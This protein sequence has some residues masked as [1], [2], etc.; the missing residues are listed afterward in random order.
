MDQIRHTLLEA[1]VTEEL[2]DEWVSDV[3]SPS[4]FTFDLEFH[5]ENRFE[6]Y[7]ATP[8]SPREVAESGAFVYAEGLLDLDIVGSGDTYRLAA[9]VS[10]DN[11]QL[12]SSTPPRRAQMRTRRSTPGTRLRSTPAPRSCDSYETLHEKTARLHR[13]LPRPAPLRCRPRRHRLRI[14]NEPPGHHS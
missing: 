4:E 11:L 7:V 8:G 1:G 10:S 5:D 13:P 3:G 9:D 2:A 6:F 14:L 12:Q